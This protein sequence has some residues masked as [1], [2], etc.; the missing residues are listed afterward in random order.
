MLCKKA[1]CFTTFFS[2]SSSSVFN[3]PLN[4]QTRHSSNAKTTYPLAQKYINNPEHSMNHA[5]TWW[6]WGRGLL[7]SPSG[8]LSRD[9][10]IL[11]L[12]QCFRSF[13]WSGYFTSVNY[14][15]CYFR[16]HQSKSDM[17]NVGCSNKMVALRLKLECCHDSSEEDYT[18]SH[19][20]IGNIYSEI[21]SCLK[22][23]CSL[24]HS[25]GVRLVHI[26]IH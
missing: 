7:F 2:A 17:W 18:E 11:L 19:N 23:V 25:F 15:W 20:L 12:K 9:T 4:P 5:T 24:K 6:G 8:L 22:A 16:L 3:L 14:C 1:S 26:V 21:S 13:H 10:F